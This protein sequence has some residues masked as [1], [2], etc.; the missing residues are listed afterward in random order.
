[1][2]TPSLFLVG[3]GDPAAHPHR[4]G[5]DRGRTAEP[6][7]WPPDRPWSPVALAGRLVELSSP[8]N[9]PRITLAAELLLQAQ[10]LGEPGAW[11]CGRPSVFL[12][13]DMADFGIDLNAL[14]VLRCRDAAA[15]ATAADRLLRSG[16][17]T[18]VVLD[19]E[20]DARLAPAALSRLSAL[21]RRYGSVVLLLTETAED[22]SSSSP[23]VSLRAVTS[24]LRQ[25]GPRFACTLRAIKDKRQGP[26]WS[27]TEVYRG[28]AG[29]R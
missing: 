5:A 27:H 29:L 1:M 3:N 2:S 26:G 6:G 11:I 7:Q 18:V 10:L 12:P 23:L 19:L 8:G 21:A 20:A 4:Q 13:Q 24:R 28:P 17:F 9:G 22:R 25:E 15:A 14:P 16:A